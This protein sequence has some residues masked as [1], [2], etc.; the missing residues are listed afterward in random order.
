MKKI[1]VAFALMSF[2]ATSAIAHDGGRGHGG[3]GGGGWGFFYAAPFIAA[4]SLPLYYTSVWA[5]P[6]PYYPPYYPGATVIIQ[7]PTAYSPVD[8][9]SSYVAVNNGTSG[10]IEL[11]PITQAQNVNA[12]TNTTWFIYPSKG[13]S[14]EIQLSDRRDCGLWATQQLT[15]NST[16]GAV[17]TQNDSSPDYGRALGACLE[18]R[19]Y[20]VR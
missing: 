6:D 9:R 2:L 19:G 1:L 13:Q 17:G 5:R 11:G 14:P 10:V 4:L 3:G 18:G 15:T 20:V 16:H 8:S 12:P 7:S